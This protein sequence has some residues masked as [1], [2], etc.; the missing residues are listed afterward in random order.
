MY[1]HVGCD[2]AV[3]RGDGD[4]AEIGIDHLD[5]TKDE[6]IFTLFI[7]KSAKRPS[8]S[9]ADLDEY[10]IKFFGAWV[11]GDAGRFEGDGSA[12]RIGRGETTGARET[13]CYAARG[14][15]Q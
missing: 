8:C 3:V 10:D 2:G 1:H 4:C 12:G 7:S 13:K 15:K 5:G 6:T 11:G 14:G 9:G